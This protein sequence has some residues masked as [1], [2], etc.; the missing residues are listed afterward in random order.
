MGKGSRRVGQLGRTCQLGKDRHS[1]ALMLVNT[2]QQ[3]AK[4]GLPT[5]RKGKERSQLSRGL[6]GVST[7]DGQHHEGMN[8]GRNP[9]EGR[10]GAG[11]RKTQTGAR[12][13]GLCSLKRN[14]R[15]EEVDP[16]RHKCNK[17]GIKM[18]NVEHSVE[19]EDGSLGVY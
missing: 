3:R 2:A 11:E 17:M 16:R 8:H 9:R 19:G 7:R 10:E 13:E 5:G 1:C 15:D 12:G 18:L 6:L 14:R 4:E